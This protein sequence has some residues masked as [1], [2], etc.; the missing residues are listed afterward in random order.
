MTAK[1]RR[2]HQGDLLSDDVN[3]LNGA[4][5]EPQAVQLSGRK[6]VCHSQRAALINFQGNL[7]G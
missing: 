6:L 5:N 4:S 2:S 7:L 3:E 1:E